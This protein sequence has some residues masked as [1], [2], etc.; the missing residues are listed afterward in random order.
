MD[1][2]LE[3]RREAAAPAAGTVT[4]WWLSRRAQ[5]EA[6]HRTVGRSREPGRLLPTGGRPLREMTAVGASSTRDAASAIVAK[7][8]A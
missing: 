2:P 4:P 3:Q 7:P 1:A 5:E 6:E 8:A